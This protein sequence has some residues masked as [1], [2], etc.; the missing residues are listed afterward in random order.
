MLVQRL[1]LIIGPDSHT[2]LGSNIQGPSVI[3]TPDWIAEPLGTYLCYFADHKGDH[4]RLAYA[5]HVEGPWTVHPGGSLD[6]AESKFLTEAPAITAQEVAEIT[7]AYDE[8]FDGYECVDVETDLTAPHIASP[9]VRVNHAKQTIE[10][11]FHGLE[12]V[13]WQVTRYASSLDGVTF[14]VEEPLFDGTYLRMFEVKSHDYALGM[15]GQVLRRT[16]GPTEFEIGP[17]ILP[18]TSRHMAAWVDGAELRVFYSEVGDTPERI[19]MVSVDVSRRWLEW[20]AGEPVEV[21][22]PELDWEGAGE[23]LVPS[24]R[25][26][27]PSPANQLRDPYVFVDRDGQAYLFYAVAGECGIAVARLSGKQE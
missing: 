23:P 21:L 10:M 24:I 1:G 6:L 13:G 2:S 9:D 25:S 26:F 7:A 16:G 11:W 12:A 20:T 3:R 5:D 15:P 18:P 8:M 4:I 14:T 19:K 27:W 22:R 17:T